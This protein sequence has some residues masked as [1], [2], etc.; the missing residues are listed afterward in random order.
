MTSSSSKNS[1]STGD[2][3]RRPLV[4]I[5]VI[6]LRDRRILLGKRRN[7]HGSG[8]WSPPG[9]HLN[10]GETPENCA[11]REVR[12]ET[13]LPIENVRLGGVT[14]DIFLSEQKHY[15]T[16]FMIADCSV[17]TPKLLEPD[18]CEG[19]V[20]YDWTALPE[21]LFLPLRN[22]LQQRFNPFSAS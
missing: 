16:L 5:G 15:L 10:F 19:W 20:W 7:A 12:E 6:V 18:K 21:P 11:I 17:G 9:G 2:E 8:D 3:A 22:L 1:S 13:G 4:G 14:N